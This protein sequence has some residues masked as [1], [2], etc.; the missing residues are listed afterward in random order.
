MNPDT[1]LTTQQL[2]YICARQGIHCQS[3]A[4]ITTGF[5]H[6]VHRINNDL[7]LKLFNTEDR[8]YFMT[9]SA[10]LASSLSFAKPK[11]IANEMKDEVIDRDYIIM[12]YVPGES[13]G[14]VWHLATEQQREVLIKEVCSS[15]QIIT[16]IPPSEIGLETTHSWAQY[17]GR[18]IDSSCKELLDQAIVGQETVHQVE[19]F[20]QHNIHA[21]EGSDLYSVYWDVHFDNFIVNDSFELQ[22]IIDLEN[23]ELT[24]LD[25][26][27][28]VIQKQTEEPEKYLREEDEKFA[29]KEDYA[30]L[31]AYYRKYYPQMFAF[32]EGD[33]RLKIYQL[34]DVLHLLKD[35]SHVKELY[36]E[37]DRL[38]SSSIH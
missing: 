4:R 17:I 23:V 11:L 15:L 26:P 35:W 36:V 27:L 18:R 21:L 22:A 34:L 9:E 32:N 12:T 2:E 3:H 20:F 14:S 13:L 8:R 25:Y 29:N 6:E 37:L 30:N 24:A 1:K 5:T 31:R 7:I 33:V 28:F 38:T 10:L 16:S 19:A